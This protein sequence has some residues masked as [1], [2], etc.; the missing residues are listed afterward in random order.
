MRFDYADTQ[1]EVP[2][3]FTA[4]AEFRRYSEVM[5]LVYRP[6]PQIA[7]KADYRFRQYGD[8]TT[9]QELASAIT[10]LF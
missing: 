6:I 10:W 1:A 5:G 9:A 7:L 8:H 4:R 3:G 2:A